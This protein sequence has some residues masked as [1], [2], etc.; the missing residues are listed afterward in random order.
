MQA[1]F[2]SH[3]ELIQQNVK[4]HYIIITLNTAATGHNDEAYDIPI[5]HQWLLST[6]AMSLQNLYK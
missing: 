5:R 1:N 6:E 2:V 4:A 3:E